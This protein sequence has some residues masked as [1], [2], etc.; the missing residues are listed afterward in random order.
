MSAELGILLVHGIGEQKLGETIANMGEPLYR[1]LKKWIEA[2]P[3]DNSDASSSP[4]AKAKEPSGITRGGKVAGAAIQAQ[5]WPPPSTCPHGRK[6]SDPGGPRR[7]A[8][9]A[10]RSG[11]MDI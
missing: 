5:R 3:F 9:A 2:A 11:T 4:G 7:G 8:L 6:W 10:D 1:A